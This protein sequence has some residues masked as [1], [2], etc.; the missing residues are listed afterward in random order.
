MR[1]LITLSL[2]LLTSLAFA[3]NGFLE[4]DS[5]PGEAEVFI[6]GQKM[7]VTP[8]AAGQKLTIELAEGNREVLLKKEGVGSAKISALIVA[9]VAQSRS[10]P[11]ALDFIMAET[12]TNSLGMKFVPIPVRGTKVL[13]CIHETRNK[14]YAAFA[15]ETKGL[16]QSWKNIKFEF[17]KGGPQY[18]IKDDAEH[19]VVNVKWDDAWAFCAWLGAKDGKTYRLP[20]NHEWSC[21]VGIGEQDVKKADLDVRHAHAVSLIPLTDPAFPWGNKW[22]PPNNNLGNYWDLTAFRT[23]N[24]K[25]SIL[26]EPIL[27]GYAYNDDYLLTAPVMNYPANNLGI[28]DLGGNVWEWCLNASNLKDNRLLRG[29]SWRSGRQQFLP[30]RE[31][32]CDYEASSS[33]GPN[34]IQ[35]DW[36]FR[37]VLDLSAVK[38]VKEAKNPDSNRNAKSSS[39]IFIGI[40]GIILL[41]TPFGRILL[42]RTLVKFRLLLRAL[43]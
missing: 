27:I 2:G 40:V 39:S 8:K 30:I 10:V 24:N 21:A 17:Q 9:G 34:D 35:T 4:L 28:F 19:P 43:F 22:P 11:L 25:N 15:A 1:Q 23:Y 29:G 42:R 41:A 31:F 12:F 33:G 5:N 32:G 16:D 37:V 14:D 7:G 36:G 6:D 26:D 3:S 38:A 13:M 18:Q 20:T